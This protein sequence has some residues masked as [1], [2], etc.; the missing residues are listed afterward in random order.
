MTAA[1]VFVRGGGGMTGCVCHLI[2]NLQM[3]NKILSNAF[4]CQPH[5]SQTE[6]SV[7]RGI[8]TAFHTLCLLLCG[9]LLVQLQYKFM[10]LSFC[11]CEEIFK[12]ITASQ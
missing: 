9:I 3:E 5:C 12:E 10:S 1:F 4:A 2:K 8:S 6:V 11:V 7:N